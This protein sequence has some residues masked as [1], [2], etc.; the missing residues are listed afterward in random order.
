MGT[1]DWVED[2]PKIHIYVQL[3]SDGEQG[4]RF[5]LW[6]GDVTLETLSHMI[7]MKMDSL[8][9]F[10][11]SNLRLKGGADLEAQPLIGRGK[12]LSQFGVRDGD[13]ILCDLTSSELWLKLHIQLEFKGW[14]HKPI[15]DV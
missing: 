4:Q 9:Q 13:E 1:P 11:V 6:V 3:N 8:K 2:E 5:M 12:L 15:A 14:E 7:R 10:K